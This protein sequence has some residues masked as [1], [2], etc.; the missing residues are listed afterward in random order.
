MAIPED[1]RRLLEDAEFFV[2]EVLHGEK[3]SRKTKEKREALLEG[4]RQVKYR[5]Q[6]EFQLRGEGG[7]LDPSQEESSDDNQS[8]TNAPSGP[9]DNASV[10]SDAQDDAQCEDIT[11]VPPQELSSILKQGYLEKKRRDHSFFGSEWRRR[12]C[13]LNTNIF[14]YYGSEKDKQQR[15]AFYVHDAYLLQNLRKDPKKNCCFEVK[16][17]D[18]KVYQFTA[19]SV[20]EAKEWVEDILFVL[21]DMNSSF[22]PVEEEGEED[23]EDG[24]VAEDEEEE[25]LEDTYDDVDAPGA[26]QRSLPSVPAACADENQDED[27]YEELPEDDFPPPIPPDSED[28]ENGSSGNGTL[29][30]KDYYL[31]LWDCTGAEADELSFRRGDVIRVLSKDYNAYGWWVGEMEGI[32]GIVPKDYL[33]TA[34]DM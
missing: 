22:I 6:H 20:R 3:L 15:G 28:D 11:M 1:V 14:Y 12:F 23:D 17:V 25:L 5:Y 32:I 27:I 21:K 8:L 16:S 4:F 2:G 19:L 29:D 24:A 26:E 9:S 34:Y 7:D 13:V 10:A 31:G 30:Y 33:M 18:R